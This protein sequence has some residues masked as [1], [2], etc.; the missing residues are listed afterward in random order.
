M[1]AAEATAA[2]NGNGFP[3][4]AFG[5]VKAGDIK[6]RDINGDGIINTRDEVYLGRGGWFGAPLTL[7]LNLSAKW[8][9][10]TFFALGT[11]RFGAK[12]MKNNSYF[13]VDGQDKYSAVVRDRW[14]E[15]TKN[16][17]TF[18]R[19]TTQNSDNNFR[20]SD[21]WLFSA[22]QFNLQ[23]VQI[24][25]SLPS[26]ILNGKLLKELGLYVAGFNLLTVAKEQEL[27]EMNIGRAPQTRLYNFGIKGAF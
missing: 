26:K 10:F 21:F 15:Q 12:A 20:N 13:W 24:S 8:K 25:Y 27:M 4:P 23:K 16:T 9:N 14:T 17:A 6:Y 5:E 2:N 7:G 11:G 18:P 22:N 19:L 3:Q 1:D